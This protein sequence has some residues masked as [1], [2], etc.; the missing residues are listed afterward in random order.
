[1]SWLSSIKEK[2]DS[3]KNSNKDFLSKFPNKVGT[4]GYDAWGFNLKGIKP[5][6][7]A[8]RFIYEN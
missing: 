4:Y 7:E 8:C 3:N 6:D 2:I 1:M 5:Y